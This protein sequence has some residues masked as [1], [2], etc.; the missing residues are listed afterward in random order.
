MEDHVEGS[1]SMT[2]LIRRRH[3]TR[4]LFALIGLGTA[5][6]CKDPTTGTPPGVPPAAQPG[7]Q[8][9]AGRPRCEDTPGL[10]CH[11]LPQPAERAD[12]VAPPL[13]AS[14][15]ISTRTLED[16]GTVTITQ[17]DPGPFQIWEYLDGKWILVGINYTHVDPLDPNKLVEHWAFSHLSASNA[18]GYQHPGNDNSVLSEYLWFGHLGTVPTAKTDAAFQT[19]AIS[20]LSSLAQQ[21][22]PQPAKFDVPNLE[23]MNATV[24]CPPHPAGSF[25]GSVPQHTVRLPEGAPPPPPALPALPAATQ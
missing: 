9:E 22:S 25:C 23:F 21:Y 1:D 3:A 12:G 24:S 8:R 17:V 13:D 15:T 14:V 16:G 6:G 18:S 19:W 7:S 4:W 20:Q 11:G 5:F 2:T 10:R